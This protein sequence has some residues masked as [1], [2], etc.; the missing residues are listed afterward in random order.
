MKVA[1]NKTDNLTLRHVHATIVAEEK[2]YCECVFEAL[3][4]QHAVHIYHIVICVLPLS[5]DFLYIIS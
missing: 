2:Q 5:T 1:L 4:I 3:V